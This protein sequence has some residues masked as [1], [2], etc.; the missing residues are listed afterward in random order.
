M[1]TKLPL[2]LAPTRV[3]RG[4]GE[5]TLQSVAVC[6]S[7]MV[8]SSMSNTWQERSGGGGREVTAHP[9]EHLG[10]PIPGWGAPV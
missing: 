7:Q 3:C 9:S 6:C 4:G 2:P 8:I 1:G 5:L 10:V